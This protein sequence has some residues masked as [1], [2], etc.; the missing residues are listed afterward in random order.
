MTNSPTWRSNSWTRAPQGTSTEARIVSSRTWRV[1]LDG[2]NQNK[3]FVNNCTPFLS[4]TQNIFF[5][6]RMLAIAFF[7]YLFLSLKFTIVSLLI[8]S[9]YITLSTLLIPISRTH[10]MYEPNS[11]WPC[12]Q[13]ILV[14]KCH[15]VSA[16]C[17]GGHGSG[18]PVFP[19]RLRDFRDFRARVGISVG[20]SDLSFLP[21]SWHVSHFHFR[22]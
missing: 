8:L 11:K 21:R 3:Q 22:S 9:S 1:Y 13:W 10:V 19:G 7:T 5:V 17:S 18:F 2:Y 4:G 20:D 6:P 15:R 16:Q 12:S 14:A